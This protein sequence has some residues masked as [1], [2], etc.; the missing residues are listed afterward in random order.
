[1]LSGLVV[2]VDY[3]TGRKLSE[4]RDF[5]TQQK[6]FRDV[7]EVGRRHKIMNPDSMRDEYGKLVYILQDANTE[8]IQEL[9]QFSCAPLAPISPPYP[10]QGRGHGSVASRTMAQA[11]DEGAPHSGCAAPGSV[12]YE[13]RRFH[14]PE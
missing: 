10:L 8:E 11:R 7:F 6:F 9:L 2:S 5:A 4:D 13:F 12:L 14:F 1:M 3:E